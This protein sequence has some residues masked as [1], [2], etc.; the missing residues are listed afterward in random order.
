MCTCTSIHILISW[1]SITIFA[2]VVV[3]MTYSGWTGFLMPFGPAIS[4]YHFTIGLSTMEED[5]IWVI[6]EE[7]RSLSDFCSFDS[8]HKSEINVSSLT[9]LMSYMKAM[10]KLRFSSISIPPLSCSGLPS[11]LTSHKL[12]SWICPACSLEN[13]NTLALQLQTLQ[14]TINHYRKSYLLP[15]CMC[16]LRIDLVFK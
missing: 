7:L 11:R 14:F 13:F 5:F 3:L 6:H 8:F 9:I 15:E 2:N 12:N 10:K 1:W 16:I 4:H